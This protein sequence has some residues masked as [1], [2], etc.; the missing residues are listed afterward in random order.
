M[1][2][3]LERAFTEASKLSPEEQ[4][5]FAKWLLAELKSEARWQ[6]LFAGSQDEL[7]K[8]AHEALEEHRAGRTEEL[9]PDEL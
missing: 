4:D 6:E 7:A 1:T 9:D 3:L 8:L 5:A 2:E